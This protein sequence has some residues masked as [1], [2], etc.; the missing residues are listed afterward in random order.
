MKESPKT[1]FIGD[2]SMGDSVCSHTQGMTEAPDQC[3]HLE[4]SESQQ[5]GSD[6]ELATPIMTQLFN[7]PS[8]Q[9]STHGASMVMS[10]G[11]QI[12][13]HCPFRCTYM[14]MRWLLIVMD[15]NAVTVMCAFVFWRASI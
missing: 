12:F 10:G 14:Y 5:W 13:V 11:M 6:L 8:L 3:T 15:S 7:L 1:L 2:N 4:P 9:S